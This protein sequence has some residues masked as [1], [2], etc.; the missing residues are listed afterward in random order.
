MQLLQPYN[1]LNYD[2]SQMG[3]KL[4]VGKHLVVI[5]GDEITA[6]KNND[7]GMLVLNLNIIDGPLAGSGG[8]YRLNLYNQSQVACEIA[9]KQ[10]AA[11]CHVI[12]MQ[13]VIITDA[14][15]LH[16]KPF[17]VQVEPQKNTEYTEVKRVYDINGIEPGKPG[18]GQ[19]VAQ[20]Q[21]AGF[22]PRQ[23]TTPPASFTPQQQPAA[24]WGQPPAS[25]QAPAQT[26]E[27]PIQ[28]PSQQ[29]APWG[30]QSQQPVAQP[31]NNAGTAPQGTVPPWLQNK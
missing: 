18:C 7:G 28:Q 30:Q 1:P 15:Q 2:P 20:G 14:A 27:V 9:H 10:L 5:D 3:N 11:I 26:E 31:A 22:T 19:Q 12:G 29:P 23:Q 6:T 13:G 24:A 16:N 25:Q 8:S 17:Y 21:P 4:P